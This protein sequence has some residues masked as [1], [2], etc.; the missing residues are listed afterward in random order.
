M[1]FVSLSLF[2]P[3]SE[4]KREIKTPPD[5]STFNRRQETKTDKRLPEVPVPRSL[6]TNHYWGLEIGRTLCNLKNSLISTNLINR[7]A[8]TVIGGLPAV[9]FILA[10]LHSLCLSVGLKESEAIKIPT[11]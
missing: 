11:V 5:L 8:D 2:M 3:A 7:P 6:T 4:K 1:S 9:S 10:L